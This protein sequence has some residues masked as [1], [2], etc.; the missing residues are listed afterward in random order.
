MDY[1]KLK[2]VEMNQNKLNVKIKMSWNNLK[3]IKMN[4]DKL[5]WIK[6]K[7]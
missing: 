6:S 2:P 5:K 1:N 7:D 3:I 4:W